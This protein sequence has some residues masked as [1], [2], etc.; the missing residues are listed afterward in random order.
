MTNWKTTGAAS[1]FPARSLIA[2]E[3]VAVTTD[4]AGSPGEGVSVAT[5]PLTTIVPVTPLSSENAVFVTLAE[6]R[7]SEKV[8]LMG[9]LRGTLFAPLAGLVETTVGATLSPFEPPPPPIGVRKLSPE[10]VP[11]AVNAATVAT[12]T[13][14]MAMRPYAAVLR[15]GP[16][17]G[18][19]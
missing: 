9:A 11:Q 8:T 1:E 4:D 17:D 2:V 10:V 7:F 19:R 14:M 12:S 15:M 5:A 13:A 3:S 18:W 6:S 16:P